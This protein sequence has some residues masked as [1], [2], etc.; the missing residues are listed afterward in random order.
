MCLQLS[1]LHTL[2]SHPNIAPYSVAVTMNAHYHPGFT[3]IYAKASVHCQNKP[4]TKKKYSVQW[5]NVRI[6]TE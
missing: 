5:E 3:Y 4:N 2:W 1:Q 6:A